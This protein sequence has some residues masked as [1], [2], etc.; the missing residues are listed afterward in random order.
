M[1]SFIA[2][3]PRPRGFRQPYQFQLYAPG[4]VFLNL[5]R[6]IS[7]LGHNLFNPNNS[8]IDWKLVVG[9]VFF[10]LGWGI[11][12]LCPGPAIMQLSV[13]TLPV[14]V[15]WFGFLGLGMF[16]AKNLYFNM[17]RG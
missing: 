4:S 6:K 7:F 5:Y 17:A 15:I 8:V 10:G 11:G 2:F 13:F 9:A 12:G 14:H 1:E 16:I 3:C